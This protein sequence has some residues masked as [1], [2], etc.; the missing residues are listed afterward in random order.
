MTKLI[1][2]VNYQTIITYNGEKMVIPPFGVI[3]NVDLNK[4]A[5]PLPKGIL[6]KK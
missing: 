5:K 4:V 1:S 2:V 6:I 3:K